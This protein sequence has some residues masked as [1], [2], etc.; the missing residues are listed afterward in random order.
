MIVDKPAREVIGDDTFL[1]GD[2]VQIVRQRGA[3]IIEA[4]KLSS[5]LSAASSVCDHVYDW[6]HGTDEGVFTS[7]G[8]VS[9][10]SYGIKEGLV[11]SFPVTCTGGRWNI[12]QNLSIDARSR[13]LMDES[14]AELTEELEMAE[15]CLCEA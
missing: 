15:Q 4:R 6:L 8:V 9:D 7:M 11:Y 13:K 2:F 3:A 12:V 10:G 14:A 5:A 1:D